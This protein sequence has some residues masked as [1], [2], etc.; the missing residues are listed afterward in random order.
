M[1]ANPGR[2]T[3]IEQ[4]EEQVR[5]LCNQQNDALYASVF[6]PM[7]PDEAKAYEDRRAMIRR[8]VNDLEDEWYWW[9]SDRDSFRRA[10]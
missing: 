7:T 6:L 8:L 9:R 10:S 2:T 1:P 3:R 5:L 4:L